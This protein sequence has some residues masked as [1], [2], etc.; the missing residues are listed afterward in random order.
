MEVGGQAV[1]EGVMMRNKEKFAVAVRLP[2]GEIKIWNEKNSK[3][4]KMFTWPFFR[5]VGG[6]FYTLYD[7]IKALIWSSNQNLGEEEQLGKKEIIGTIALSLVMGMILFLGL[8][9]LS[10]HYLTL[11]LG[12]EGIWF[13]LLDGM[14]RMVLLV[15][16][17]VL[18]SRLK[19]VKILFQ[20]HGAEHKAIACYEQGMALSVENAR[21]C[22]RFHPRC[23]TSFL[24]LVFLISVFAFSFLPE[25]LWMKLVGRIVLL[26]VIAAVGY[27][28]IKL[29][30]KWRKNLLVK[31]MIAP[32]LWLQRITTKEPTDR[33]LE[34]GLKSLQPVVE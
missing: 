29:S 27:E 26:P 32:G 21:K 7:G 1:I 23:G 16:Y 6:L 8:P 4:P 11:W 31:V 33:Q 13:D 15:G 9:F 5:G 34:V 12:K 2:N 17:L 30:S 14:M 18:I 24:F 20:Y 3:F 22:S 28:L 25:E 19:E 10:A